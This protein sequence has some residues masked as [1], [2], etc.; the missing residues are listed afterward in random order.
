MGYLLT[1]L[2][3]QK[4]TVRTVPTL[5]R[6]TEAAPRGLMDKASVSE[7][8]DCGFE[9]RRGCTARVSITVAVQT[10]TRQIILFTHKCQ[11]SYLSR[12]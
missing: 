6:I 5:D 10:V 2:I 7:A 1:D 12:L 4:I 9:S 8:E 11:I 3:F